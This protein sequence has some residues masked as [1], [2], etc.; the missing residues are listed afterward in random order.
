MRLRITFR[1][2]VNTHSERISGESSGTFAD[3]D[4]VL[5]GAVGAGSA[6]EAAGVDAAVVLASLVRVTLGVGNAVTCSQK[7]MENLS[8]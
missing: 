8:F 6:G 4:V 3:G 7:N 5:D 2:N 1:K